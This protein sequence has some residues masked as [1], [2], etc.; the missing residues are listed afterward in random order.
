MSEPLRS[1]SKGD[2]IPRDEGTW[3]AIIE[4][5]RLATRGGPLTGGPLGR[6]ASPV[7]TVNVRND[8][9]AAL[10]AFAIVA[11]GEPLIDVEAEPHEH[12]RQLTFPGTEPAAATDPFAILLAPLA[13]DEVGDSLGLERIGVARPQAVQ[14]EVLV[15]EVVGARTREIGQRRHDRQADQRA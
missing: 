3:N 11:L 4:A 1:V 8:T 5:G 7:L 10:A 9:G 12:Q 14:V 13:E 6:G 2:A 15:V